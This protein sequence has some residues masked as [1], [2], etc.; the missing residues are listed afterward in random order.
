MLKTVVSKLFGIY[1]E[2]QRIIIK[3]FGIKIK[4]KWIAINPLE[5]TCNIYGLQTLL[6]NGT[7]FP[8]PIGIVIGKHAKIGK[9][10]KIYQNTT[11]GNGKYNKERD[12][13]IPIIGDNVTIYANCNIVGGIIIGDNAVIG[14]GSVVINDVEANTVV[15]GNPAKV[16]KR[17]EYGK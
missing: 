12:R 9:N 7:V 8:H 2:N 17:I 1:K 16:I 3:I 10:C 5:D 15:A 4:L 14:A 13:S 6:N 11:I